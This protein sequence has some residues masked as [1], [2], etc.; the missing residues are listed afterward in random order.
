MKF[1]VIVPI[2]NREEIIEN[3]INSVIFQSYPE[4]ECLLI[5]D[6]SI[7]STS[8][9]CKK[10]VVQNK[11]V[12][13][14]YK[15]NGG[16]SSARNYGIRK[17]TG[18]FIVFLDSDNSL[19][20]NALEKL[21]EVMDDTYDFIVYG[22]NTSSSIQWIPTEKDGELIIERQAIREVYLPTHFNIY[23]QNKHF[24]KN[25]V[26]NKAYR[27]SFLKKNE[28]VFDESRRTWED[29]IF[30][31]NCLDK[32]S[33]IAILP[34]AIYNAYCDQGGVDHLSSQLYLDQVLQY[35]N[36]EREYK[37]RFGDEMNF[38]TDHYI[39]SN[40]NII[41]SMFERMVQTFGDDVLP[42]IDRAIKIDIVRYWADKYNPEHEKEKRLKEYILQGS[43]SKIYGIYH[44]PFLALPE[45]QLGALN[46]GK[47][48]E[49]PYPG[50]LYKC[51]IE[52]M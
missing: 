13:Y 37:S 17:A 33:K 38:S 19:S 40:F 16:V 2:F 15:E 46:I 18:D 8:E 39:R 35:I 43:A 28:I 10:Y 31:I 25:F 24:L 6:G 12:K 32:A 9:I 30:V 22:F 29:G 1:S 5:D 11:K 47:A 48:V 14:F 7:D 52:K 27:T 4:W 42:I 44:L 21:N 41:N 50:F 3:V 26:W 49:F 51:G 20:K 45:K 36:D 23:A 34:E